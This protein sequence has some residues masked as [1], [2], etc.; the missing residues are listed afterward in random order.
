MDTKLQQL[1]ETAF[2][3]AVREGALTNARKRFAAGLE[4]KDTSVY[5]EIIEYF[6]QILARK[7]T[8]SKTQ[9]SQIRLPPS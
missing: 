8:L 4:A 2:M 5:N 7:K 6:D 3:R 9:S 1:P